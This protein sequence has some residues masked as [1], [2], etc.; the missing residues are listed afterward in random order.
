MGVMYL[1]QV[2]LKRVFKN[3][4]W[5]NWL[6]DFA[7][8]DKVGAQIVIAQYLRKSNKSACFIKTVMLFLKL[9][10]VEIEANL[11][12]PVLST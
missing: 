6:A 2:I 12:S 3:L 5:N 4:T 10:I 11:F 7:D 9:L 8:S 1:S